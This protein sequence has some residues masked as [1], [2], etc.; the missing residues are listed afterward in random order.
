[1]AGVTATDVAIPTLDVIYF[2]IALNIVRLITGHSVQTT[3]LSAAALAVTGL[4]TFYLNLLD[5]HYSDYV[6]FATAVFI[7][8]SYLFDAK[9]VPTTLQWK[10]LTSLRTCLTLVV[11]LVTTV[12]HK[13]I[14]CLLV[15]AVI[16]F[17]AT[18]KAADTLAATF[19]AI[20]DPTVPRP[21]H[22]RIVRIVLCTTEDFTRSLASAP[23][24]GY[25]RRAAQAEDPVTCLQD[26]GEHGNVNRRPLW[27]MASWFSST[28]LSILCQLLHGTD[29]PSIQVLSGHELP[30]FWSNSIC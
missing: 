14:R 2:G 15:V 16:L 25:V 1:M 6:C 28:A 10:W 30:T 3:V 23:S 22:A 8:F 20:V 9:H 17:C 12:L 24:T 18:L 29:C 27:R 4:V 5:G 11:R 13:L 7:A 21:C 19:L 26:A